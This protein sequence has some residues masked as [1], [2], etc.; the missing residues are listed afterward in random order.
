MTICALATSI[1]PFTIRIISGDWRSRA[2]NDRY[3]GLLWPNSVVIYRFGLER[4]VMVPQRQDRN[5]AVKFSREDVKG[6]IL[7]R[8]RVSPGRQLL[9]IRPR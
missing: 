1:V 9:S 6:L 5:R 8:D 7:K 4:S 3:G 2:D